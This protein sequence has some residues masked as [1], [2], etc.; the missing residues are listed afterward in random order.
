MVLIP[1]GEFVMGS[2]PGEG[3][4]DEH[5]Q[6]RIYLDAFY[7]A[8]YE[9]T[10]ARYAKFL[11]ATGSEKPNYW[12]KVNLNNH[13]NRPV[14]GVNWHDAKAYCGWA[15]KRLPTEAEWEKA[16]RGTD[17]RRYPWGDSAPTSSLANYDRY[18][19]NWEGDL[20][21]GR[22]QD[23]DSYETGKSPYGIYDMAGSVWEWVADWYDKDYYHGLTPIGMRGGWI[24]KSKAS[25]TGW[26]PAQT[27]AFLLY[28][29]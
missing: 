1:A 7:I 18:V 12:D 27:L 29:G 9:V 3:E 16:A 11:R 19:S 24:G 4:D 28:L 22:L 10:T 26:K 5:P 8:K 15:G 25:Q 14:V 23:I 21:D 13:S 17:G 6:K 20:Y 2:P